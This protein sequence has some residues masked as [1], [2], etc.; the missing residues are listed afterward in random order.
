MQQ[1]TNSPLFYL[2]T[3]AATA[4]LANA[5][6]GSG[7][8]FTSGALYDFVVFDVDQ[9]GDLDVLGTTASSSGV[10]ESIENL[11][12]GTYG[13]AQALS[14]FDIYY[15]HIELGDLSGDGVPDAI[16]AEASGT[17]AWY[18]YLGPTSYGPAQTIGS[19]SGGASEL[20][21]A[22][23]DG[24]GDLDIAL[25]SESGDDLLWIENQGGGV[26]GAN[27]FVSSALNAPQAVEAADL[28]GDGDLDLV[29]VVFFED[30]V[31]WYPNLGGGTFGSQRVISSGADG[32][33]DVAVADLDGDGRLDVLSAS[34]ND[35]EV[36][37]YRNLGGGTFASQQIV[38]L[39]TGTT[40]KVGAAD[41]DM[42]GL[43]DI[44]ASGVGSGGMDIQW[45]QNIGFGFFGAG[46]LV[47]ANLSASGEIAVYDADDDSD[48]DF[49][50]ATGWTPSESDLGSVYCTSN[51]NSTGVNGQLRVTGTATSS[52]NAITLNASD[53]PLSTFGFFITSRTADMVSNPAGSQ[54]V[55]C[56]G[57]SIGRYQNEIRFTGVTGRFKVTIDLDSMPTP[58]SSVPVL[59]GQTWRFQA[60]HR[61]SVGGTA[62]SNFTDATA[63]LFQ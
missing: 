16:V 5:Q 18:E 60:W 59:V 32:P 12:D 3:F 39:T 8:P 36:A 17:V 9:D 47:A 10:L 43:L 57:G 27:V 40:N 21:V 49:V 46:Q 26:F 28:D 14:P 34:Q 2:A 38:G 37:W 50:Y 52:L 48:V 23:L 29:T 11:G 45:H 51:P 6:F 4:G 22:D 30:K 15:G 44:Y 1:R 24:D 25:V 56:L 33:V 20:D 61:D 13:T 53:L 54:G 58:T 31:A 63:V 7:Q 19:V 55:L 41:I 35:S 62:T 42:D